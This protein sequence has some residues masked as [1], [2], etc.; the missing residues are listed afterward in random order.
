M[1]AMPHE[2]ARPAD[3]L[4]FQV[5]PLADGIDA[6][7]AVRA[8][9]VARFDRALMILGDSTEPLRPF[10]RFWAA[11]HRGM[12]VGLAVRFEAFAHPLVSVVADEPDALTALLLPAFASGAGTLVTGSDQ[13]LPDGLA[14]APHT[15]DPWLVSRC[16]A[17]PVPA[18]VEPL[19]EP[20]ELRAFYR[21]L[22]M[23][24]WSPA[25]L[26]NGHVF[27]VRAGD[28][29]LVCAAGVNFILPAQDY[30]QVGALATHPGFRGRSFATRTLT[31][32]RASLAAADIHE[33][34]VLADARD[35][36]L[37]AFYGKLGFVPRGSFRFIDQNRSFG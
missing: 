7:P 31:A 23:D 6:S 8:W 13:V 28:G 9:A 35:P 32:V 2:E 16:S 37:T 15:A 34:G 14:T 10:S 12:P 18:G 3:G 24:F 22:G 20:D 27:G 19:Q 29:S 17:A 26:R 33:C 36:A 5:E 1:P 4:P 30:A 11:F 21:Q 25:M